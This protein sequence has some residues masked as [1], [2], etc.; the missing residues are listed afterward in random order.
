MAQYKHA[1]SQLA[2]YV[3]NAKGNVCYPRDSKELTWLNHKLGAFQGSVLKAS[4]IMAPTAKP[5]QKAWQEPE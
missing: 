3:G 4:E 2:F 1:S 5:V